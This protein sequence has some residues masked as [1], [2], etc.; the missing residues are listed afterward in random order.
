MTKYWHVTVCLQ[1]E[2]LSGRSLRAS[3]V[4]TKD[5][6]G[7]VDLSG[8]NPLESEI[9]FFFC[10]FLRRRSRCFYFILFFI[11]FGRRQ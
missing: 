3:E 5:P 7:P 6:F 8:G 4:V 2:A 11:F 10:D 1:G 9:E